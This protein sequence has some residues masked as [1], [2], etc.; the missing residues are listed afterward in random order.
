MRPIGS[1][2]HPRTTP[3][4]TP[5]LRRPQDRLSCAHAM[6]TTE[7]IWLEQAT[8]EPFVSAWMSPSRTEPEPSGLN[9]VEGDG[10]VPRNLCARNSNMRHQRGISDLLIPSL[11]LCHH[12]SL[13]SRLSLHPQEGSCRR[14]ASTNCGSPQRKRPSS[15]PS[16]RNGT[17]R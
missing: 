15:P 8:S 11:H 12:R 6:R 3:V 10:G 14:T 16:Q 5:P 1:A 17:P 9:Q 2:S 13:H 4:L 7:R